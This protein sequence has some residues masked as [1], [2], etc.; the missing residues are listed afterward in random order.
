M[1]FKKIH[2]DFLEEIKKLEVYSSNGEKEKI[3]LDNKEIFQEDYFLISGPCSIESYQQLDEIA[4]KI[5]ENGGKYLRAGTFKLRTNPNSFQGL[6]KE[7][8]EILYKIGKKY[9][10]ITVSELP[11]LNYLD[12][13]LKYVDVIVVG[14]RNMRNFEMLKELGKTNKP[15]IL[16]RGDSCSILEL[17]YAS[18]YIYK[19]G[20]KNII[21]CERGI[22]SFETVTRNTIDLAG[23]MLVN[24]YIR[25]K[26]ILD[27]SH[28]LGFNEFVSDFVKIAKFSKL[29]GSIIEVTTDPLNAKSDGFQSL[30]IPT[31]EKLVKEL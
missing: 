9:D 23:I 2:T 8:L 20:N 6:G 29:N 13:F 21:L 1:E 11:S 5:K 27:P 31:Y 26:T 10:L 14:M 15:I 18:L 4:K 30:D 22:K 16:K 19:N 28:G 25:F 7:G 12:L 3:F 17:I 24:K